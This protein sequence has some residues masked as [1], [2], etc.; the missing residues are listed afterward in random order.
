MEIIIV[1]SVMGFLCWTYCMIVQRIGIE[2]AAEW[3]EF[4]KAHPSW[5]VRPDTRPN[6]TESTNWP[7]AEKKKYIEEMWARYLAHKPKSIKME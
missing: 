5:F 7:E 2:Q 1:I 4:K 3:E 6:S